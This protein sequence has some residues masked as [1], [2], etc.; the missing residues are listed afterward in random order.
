MKDD[1]WIERFGS[2][3][4]K[5]LATGAIPD[6]SDA[7]EDYVHMLRLTQQLQLA[8]PAAQ[9]QS[10]PALRQKFLQ[11]LSQ[12][13]SNRQHPKAKHPAFSRLAWAALG[14]VLLLIL[15][16]F[17]LPSVRAL[18]QELARQI[19]N[20]VVLNEPSDAE[21]YISTQTS[22]I[23][24]PTRD[25]SFTCTDCPEPQVV[26]MLTPLEASMKAGFPVYAP[27][28]IPDGFNLSTRDVLTSGQSITVDASYRIEYDQPFEPGQQ[29]TGLIV[30]NQSLLLDG[31][32]EW[33]HPVGDTPIIDIS[34]R[35]QPG[36]WLEQ[37]PVYPYQNENGGWEMTRWNQIL[38]SEAGYNF[39]L[40]TNL[41]T[42]I[43]PLE[44][45]L[46]IA[47]SLQP[48]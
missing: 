4:E 46:K 48:E 18:A 23:P 25:P 27:A 21:Q 38:W 32:Q 34:V 42:A 16:S 41:P 15:A 36:I 31:A 7:P 3:V 30:I 35:G 44:E 11:E 22:G 29:T 20:F 43:L 45:L 47:E 1:Q 14:V 13:E 24:T 6:C 19:G 33:R 12:P 28:Y 39:M 2:D 9:S 17:A 5:I 40:Q 10:M 26:G 37:V 8:D